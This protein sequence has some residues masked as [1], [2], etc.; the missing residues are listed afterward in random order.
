MDERVA[1]EVL[2]LGGEVGDLF[3]GGEP[4]VEAVAVGLD[5]D[6]GEHAGGVA[7]DVGE[8]A[9]LA[10]ADIG[11]AEGVHG[12]AHHPGGRH[13]GPVR[14]E[15]RVDAGDARGGGAPAEAVAGAGDLRPVDGL[16]PGAHIGAGERHDVAELTIGSPPP[17]SVARY[18]TA[19]HYKLVKT[20]SDQ[21]VY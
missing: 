12:P 10:A 20:V 5:R 13:R 15:P 17:R 7:E 9:G 6:G 8:V 1:G 4:I 16:V 19:R 21:R 11:R 18:G 2:P 3:D 14:L